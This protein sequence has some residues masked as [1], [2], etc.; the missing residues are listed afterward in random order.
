MLSTCIKSIISCLTVSAVVLTASPSFAQ[1]SFKQNKIVETPAGIEVYPAEHDVPMLA[2]AETSV[3]P[4]AVSPAAETVASAP[5]TAEAPA[6]EPVYL[7]SDL[8]KKYNINFSGSTTLDFFSSYIWRGQSLD[9]DSVVQPGISFSLNELTVG[10]WGNWDVDSRDTLSSGESDYYVSLTKAI[11]DYLTVSVGHTWYGFPGYHTNSK[12]I[13]ASVTL[14]TL[15]LT[16][17]FFF[18]HDYDEGKIN[19]MTGERN[20]E[21]NYYALSLSQSIPLIA[22]Y[23]TSLELG[24]TIGYVDHQWLAGQGWHVTPSVGLKIALAKN[25]TITPTMGYNFPLEDLKDP[26]IGNQNNKF[27]SAVKTAYSF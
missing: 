8:M 5:E 21:S 3:A 20:G 11:T 22:K 10:Y 6:E 23:G 24:T 19:L 18:A 26:N 9:R 25:I 13:Y 16:P 7:V 4:V 1:D 17:V 14:T 2:Q 15:P 12:E 27:F